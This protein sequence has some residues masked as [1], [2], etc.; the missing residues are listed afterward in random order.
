MFI[1]GAQC[2]PVSEF[3]DVGP[4][5]RSQLDHSSPSCL[6]ACEVHLEAFSNV[7]ITSYVLYFVRDIV[8]KFLRQLLN[9]VTLYPM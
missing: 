8:R 6:V 9:N 3:D 4:S 5:F 7:C 1:G 2:T